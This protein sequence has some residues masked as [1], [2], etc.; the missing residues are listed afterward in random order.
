MPPLAHRDAGGH[1][2]ASL[3]ARVRILHRVED[4]H[5]VEALHGGEDLQ[6]LGAAETLGEI[7]LTQEPLSMG[8][9]FS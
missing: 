9:T 7:Q 6:A 2:V 1:D 4:L 3:P 5:R 8:T